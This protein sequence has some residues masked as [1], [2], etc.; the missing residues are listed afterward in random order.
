MI[1]IDSFTSNAEMFSN[2]L[3][4]SELRLHLFNQMLSVSAVANW[5]YKSTSFYVVRELKQKKD[6]IGWLSWNLSRVEFYDRGRLVNY[7]L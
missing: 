7:S 5:I 6:V 1:W 3:F 4:V 2:N